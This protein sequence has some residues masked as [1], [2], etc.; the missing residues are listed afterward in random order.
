M[1]SI[2]ETLSKALQIYPDVNLDE[3]PRMA[4]FS[5]YGY[6][7]AEAFG[8]GYGAKFIADYKHNIR[9]ATES[10]V[11]REPVL[12]CVVH[13]A[14]S[15]SWRG[16]MSELLSKVQKCYLN[17]YAAKNL[18]L[19]FP[20]NPIALAKKLN[21]HKHELEKVG[22]NIETGR[23]KDRFVVISKNSEELAPNSTITPK[24]DEFHTENR[25]KLIEDDV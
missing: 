21:V 19:T 18:P 17:F 14:E 16:T 7:V 20:D 23:S 22:V 3:Y 5:R 11:E 6:A 9:K 15:G 8:E 25:K 1:N 12:N 13:L 2:F 24:K 10:L 4:D